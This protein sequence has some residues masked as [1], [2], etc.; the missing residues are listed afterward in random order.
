LRFIIYCEAVNM[1]ND[2]LIPGYYGC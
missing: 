1:M 2:D